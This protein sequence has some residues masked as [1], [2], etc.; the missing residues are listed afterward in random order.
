[1]FRGRKG[2]SASI[3]CIR[4]LSWRSLFWRS[5]SDV[6]SWCVAWWGAVARWWIRNVGK[7]AAFG[8][9]QWKD[10]FSDAETVEEEIHCW[11]EAE[12]NTPLAQMSMFVWCGIW[13]AELPRHAGRPDMQHMH[14][15]AGESSAQHLVLPSPAPGL[16]MDDAPCSS[17]QVITRC[18]SWLWH[19][20]Y[21]PTPLSLHPWHCAVLREL[22]GSSTWGQ[23]EH[24]HVWLF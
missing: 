23:H 6:F 9:G 20:P 10:K 5:L 2:G 3:F 8:Q 18:S 1:M 19:A 15:S 22:S 13:P 11:K 12:M 7:D 16:P 14:G 24:G 17:R 21:M 4:R